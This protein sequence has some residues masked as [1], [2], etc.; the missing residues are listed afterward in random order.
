MFLARFCGLAS[1]GCKSKLTR[2]LALKSVV[3]NQ[4]INY[5]KFV[6]LAKLQTMKIETDEF[7]SLFTPEL[8]KLSELFRKYDYEIRI[9]GGAVRD[10]LMGK[11]PNDID[12]ATTATPA[13]MKLMFEKEEIRMISAKGEKHGTITARINDKENFEVTTL[14]IDV[15]TDGRHAEV[16]FTKDWQLDASRRDLTINSMFLDL[17]GTVYDYFKGIDDLNNLHVR[18]VGDADTRIKEDYLRILRYFRFYGRIVQDASTHDPET[19]NAIKENLSGLEGI[20]G[21]RLWMELRKIL[22]GRFCPDVVTVMLE[23]GIGPYIGLSGNLDTKNLFLVYERSIELNP[24]SMTLLSAI[25][26]SKT[27]VQILHKR[28]KLSNNE[29]HVAEFIVEY[30]DEFI[31]SEDKERFCRHK[32]VELLHKDPK[33]K[34]KIYELLKYCG[35]PELLNK[36]EVWKLPKFPVDGKSLIL[37]G[38]KGPMFNKILTELRFRWIQSEF[39][40]SKNELL[41][42]IDE[43]RSKFESS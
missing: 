33:I 41:E 17:D 29:V 19:L 14:R 40:L 26:N 24:M 8:I 2:F 18:F 1:A 36:F 20:S 37:L 34:M 25:L 11:I 5:S 4:Y 21:E 31:D 35:E 32:A 6:H 10:L 7:R 23:C 42:Q 15:I 38:V 27:E 9:A 28:L 3:R 12:F 22:I 30:R 39:E 16:E 13:Q 43:V